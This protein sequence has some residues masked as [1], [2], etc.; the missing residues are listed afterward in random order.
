MPPSWHFPEHRPDQPL[1]NSLASELFSGADEDW[2]PGA[3]LVREC[4]QN[5]L[6][7]IAS[8]QVKVIFQVR[9]AGALSKSVANH[10]FGDLWP[11]LLAPDCKLAEL[12][13]KP[14]S[15][16]YVVVEDFGTT[17]LEGDV[18]QWTLK[19]ETNRFFNFVRAE[20]LSGNGQAAN[21]GGSWGVG[22]TVFNRCSRINSFLALT[23]R[24]ATADLAVFGRSMLRHH[25]IEA[26][27][28]EFQGG[29][30]WGSKSERLRGLVVPCQ[31]Q[32][33]AG[34]LIRDFG[35]QRT[36]DADGTNAGL[37]VV[38]P[39]ADD[40]ITA[41]GIL[42]I[43]MREYFYP[44]L[45]GKLEVQVHGEFRD[46]SQTVTLTRENLPQRA[47]QS[48]EN[49]TKDV[50][51]LATRALE[52]NATSTYEAA[53][54][55]TSVAPDW[56][57]RPFRESDERFNEL[58]E[59]FDQGEY[60]AIRVPIT[61]HP[62]EGSPE[63]DAF[64]VHLRRDLD[65]NGYRPLFVRGWTVVANAR[66]RGL[67]N[68]SV[69]A[70]TTIDKDGALGKF[71]RAAEPPAHTSWQH[72]TANIRGRYKFGKA[73]IDFVVGAPKYIVDCLANARRETDT[74]VWADL[75]PIPGDS[76]RAD[77]ASRKDRRKK[78]GKGGTN[79][80]PPPPPPAKPK[81]YRIS[82]IEGGFAVV[83]D[84]QD[85]TALPEEILV[86]V[87]YDRS[88]GNPIKSHSNDDFDIRDLGRHETNL[89]IIDYPANNSDSEVKSNNRIRFKPLDD[90][91]RLEVTGFDS[92]RDLVV[93]GRAKNSS[94]SEG[95]AMDEATE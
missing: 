67:R 41:D 69:F 60:I 45:A 79:P 84:N 59:L 80:P 83:R 63:S 19:D 30:L 14:S 37:S 10:W 7:A 74:L 43:A 40:D 93:I 58:C 34:K 71:L 76:D 24:K 72:D 20:G 73:T 8:E 6:D 42:D 70:L 38:I 25:R 53:I 55:D 68:H 62:K 49:T 88:R 48:P 36:V 50:V 13:R 57:S 9:K 81:A 95:D 26:D 15:G 65:G 86:M 78:K 94:A 29:G 3:D 92:R 66:K 87:G 33:T 56:S 46:G 85:R 44:I 1:H 64:T 28:S 11:H 31:D 21:T 16:G 51:E 82:Q 23:V 61:I 47:I 12:E 2:S 5:S 52:L 75:F 17:G 27:H 77:A 54:G 39:Y 22:K 91:F 4:I 35:L 89:E 32:E 90:C 18:E